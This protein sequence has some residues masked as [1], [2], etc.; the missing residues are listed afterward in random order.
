MKRVRIE[1][2]L[3]LDKHTIEEDEDYYKLVVKEISNNLTNE[4]RHHGTS[5]LDYELIDSK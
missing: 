4:L 2:D 1:I 5:N 3:I